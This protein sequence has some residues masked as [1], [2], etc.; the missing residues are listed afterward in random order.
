MWHIVTDIWQILMFDWYRFSCAEPIASK[1]RYS[2]MGISPY[3]EQNKKH[4][5]IIIRTHVTYRFHDIFIGQALYQIM[6]NWRYADCRISHNEGT[7]YCMRSYLTPI[8][9]ISTCVYHPCIICFDD[10]YVW[11]AFY[12]RCGEMPYAQTTTKYYFHW[13]NLWKHSINMYKQP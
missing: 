4:I 5:D 1:T 3:F 7:S 9:M 12:T 11:I 8:W 10:V 6:F 2:M 13:R